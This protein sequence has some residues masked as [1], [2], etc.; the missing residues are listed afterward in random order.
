MDGRTYG[1]TDIPQFQFI[2]SSLSDD[3]KCSKINITDCTKHNQTQ[4]STTVL[5]I[6]AQ[7]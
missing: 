5:L 7:L 2:R 6:T 1:R 3:L 4:F